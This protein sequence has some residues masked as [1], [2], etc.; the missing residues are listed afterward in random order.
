MLK[1]RHFTIFTDHKPIAYTFQK[2]WGK[3]SPRNFNH[4]DFVAQFTTDIRHISGQNNVITNVLSRVKSITAPQS[5]EVLPASQESNN[6]FQILLVST[7]DLELEKKPIPSTSVSIYCDMSTGKPWSYA[8]VP[9]QYWVFQ[10]IYDLAPRHQ[11]N[12]ETGH[13]FCVAT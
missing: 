13:T 12:S 7:T 3:C 10:S 5:H 8:P 11:S 6:T 4:L 9:L 1:M 2:K